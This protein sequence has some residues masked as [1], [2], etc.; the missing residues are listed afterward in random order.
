MLNQ[1]KLLLRQAILI[2][3]DR[4]SSSKF[5]QYPSKKRIQNLPIIL[6]YSLSFPN[7]LLGILLSTSYN[8]IKYVD[9]EHQ[10]FVR[11]KYCRLS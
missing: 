9:H 6:G 1:V 8:S 2:T 7:D 10:N 5:M 11:M 3:S 4:H